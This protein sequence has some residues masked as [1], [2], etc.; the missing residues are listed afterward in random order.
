[1]VKALGVA[2]GAGWS[3]G[4]AHA[5]PVGLHDDAVGE[6]REGNEEQPLFGT[7]VRERETGIERA[8]ER[9][10]PATG[11]CYYVQGTGSILYFEYDVLYMYQGS[12]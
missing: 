5:L 4:G 9:V 12:E 8:A 3:G 1:M 6:R 10:L 7:E 2:R 11:L